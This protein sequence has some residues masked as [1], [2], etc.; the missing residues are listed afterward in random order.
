MEAEDRERNS[1]SLIVKS[2]NQ[3]LD[4]HRLDQVNLNW[5]VRDLKIRLSR[6]F[7]TKPVFKR[8]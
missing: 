2:P 1:I 4:Q 8:N 6:D 3:A 5:T 7:P